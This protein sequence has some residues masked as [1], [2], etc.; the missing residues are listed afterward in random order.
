MYKATW[1][2]GIY[3]EATGNTPQEA[4]NNLEKKLHDPNGPNAEPHLEVDGNNVACGPHIVGEITQILFVLMKNGQPYE[5]PHE[6][7]DITRQLK[8]TNVAVAS[9][10]RHHVE[11]MRQ[12]LPDLLDSDHGPE[13]FTIAKY[14]ITPKNLPEPS[15]T[16]P[17]R[18]EYR[19]ELTNDE[20]DGGNAEPYQ[21]INVYFI[22]NK[23]TTY[24][25]AN[26]IEENT[27]YLDEACTTTLSG[28]LTVDHQTS[29]ISGEIYDDN[30]L[31]CE[32]RSF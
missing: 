28:S 14:T 29:V 13:Q 15:T 22:E 11:A 30:G 31:I 32:Y 6:H 1:T 16:P 25:W 20:E 24:S 8:N 10:Q 7:T 21:I 3:Q 5:M 18:T 4:V 17:R 26:G 2:D 12:A 23:P 19:L 27:A 9:T